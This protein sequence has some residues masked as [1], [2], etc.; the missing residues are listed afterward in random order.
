MSTCARCGATKC[1]RSL[2]K[3]VDLSIELEV[4]VDARR[5]VDEVHDENRAQGALGALDHLRGGLLDALCLRLHRMRGQDQRHVARVHACILH[6][7]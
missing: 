1:P 4:A 3:V 7:L 6:V 2:K 5:Q